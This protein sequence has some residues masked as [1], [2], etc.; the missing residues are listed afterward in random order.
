MLKHHCTFWP[1]FYSFLQSRTQVL[2]RF[3]KQLLGKTT[4]TSHLE[5]GP[6]ATVSSLPSL[7]RNKHGFP[8]VSLC[9]A[10][11]RPAAWLRVEQRAA[12][13]ACSYRA[14]GSDPARRLPPKHVDA[15]AAFSSTAKLFLS[16]S[17]DQGPHKEP[18]AFSL[19]D[20]STL[21]TRK[22]LRA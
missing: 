17:R 16:K 15:H 12:S 1:F 21:P 22:L 10:G 6:C 11:A 19:G 18:T 4:P 2:L 20:L 5:G 13:S 9:I 14:A 7:G 3:P 8:S